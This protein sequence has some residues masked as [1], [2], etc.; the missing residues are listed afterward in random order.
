[1]RTMNS[2][3]TR[4]YADDFPSLTGNELKELIP[5]PPS[6]CRSYYSPGGNVITLSR[7]VTDGRCP[8]F[9]YVLSNGQDGI[10]HT[11]ATQAGFGGVRWWYVCPHCHQRCGRLYWTH[12]RA[13]CRQCLN[14]YY[15]CQSK[16]A[17]DRRYRSIRKGR[18]AIWG[19]DTP[20][21]NFLLKLL[22]TYRKPK[23]MHWRNYER[24]VRRQH[25][26]EV[27]FLHALLVV[28]RQRYRGER[29]CKMVWRTGK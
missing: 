28:L 15:R 6:P 29:R 8:A 13:G 5:L 4:Q 20:D 19:K 11:T 10:L 24:R 17:A 7:R 3:A 23:G 12:T 14:L 25:D 16:S 2:R 9:R 22:S 18:H 26:R 27:C 21:I 1:M